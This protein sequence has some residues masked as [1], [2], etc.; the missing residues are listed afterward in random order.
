MRFAAR[1]RKGSELNWSTSPRAGGFSLEFKSTV[2]RAFRLERDNNVV[3]HPKV[4]RAVE[5]RQVTITIPCS[6]VGEVGPGIDQVFKARAV[7]K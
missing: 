3:R 6:K 7:L 5:G 1:V 4:R 2:G